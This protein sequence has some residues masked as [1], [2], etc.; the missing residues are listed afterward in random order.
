MKLYDSYQS[1]PDDAMIRPAASYPG[2]GVYRFM[3]KSEWLKERAMPAAHVL[4][5]WEMDD[6]VVMIHASEALTKIERAL[7]EDMVG[8]DFAQGARWAIREMFK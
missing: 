7:V 2:P 6:P 4:G 1:V 8:K 3:L 5:K